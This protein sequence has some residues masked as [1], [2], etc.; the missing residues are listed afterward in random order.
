MPGVARAWCS[1]EAFLW[2]FI[3]GGCASKRVEVITEPQVRSVDASDV[4]LP[5]VTLPR[6]RKSPCASSA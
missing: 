3:V 1:V 5:H 2:A 6:Y 4:T